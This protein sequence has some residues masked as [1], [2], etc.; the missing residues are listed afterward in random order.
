M[1]FHSLKLKTPKDGEILIDYSKNLINKDV[2]DKLM[3][4]AQARKV[5]EARDAMFSG[6]IINNTEKR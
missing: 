6:K 4:L 2:F 5:L 3:G 1:F